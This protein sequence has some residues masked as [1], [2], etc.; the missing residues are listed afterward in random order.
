ML[1]FVPHR[2]AF[3]PLGMHVGEVDGPGE[4]AFEPVS[5]VGHGIGLDVP[6]HGNVVVVGTDRDLGLDQGSGLGPA[7]SFPLLTGPHGREKSIDAARADG[8][9]PFAQDVAQASVFLFVVWQPLFDHRLEK[10]GTGLVGSQPDRLEYFAVRFCVGCLATSGFLPAEGGTHGPVHELDRMLTA[11]AAHLDQL[12]KQSA[13]APSTTT[14]GAHSH[15]LNILV[16]TLLTHFGW[17]IHP[18]SSI[19]TQRR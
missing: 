6:G 1:P 13:F 3:G 4:V 5:A 11:H 9:E 15:L 8:L 18:V 7:V 14:L 16:L 19:L 12:I 10:L 2:T 17:A